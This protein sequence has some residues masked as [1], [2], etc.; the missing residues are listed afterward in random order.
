MGKRGKEKRKQTYFGGLITE[1]GKGTWERTATS[2]SLIVSCKLFVPLI[3]GVQ[4]VFLYLDVY[5]IV[6]FPRGELMFS[7]VMIHY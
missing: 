5:V 6:M 7:C 3:E 2:T 1:L 4:D